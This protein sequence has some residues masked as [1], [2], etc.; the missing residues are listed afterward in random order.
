[1][2]TEPTDANE[3]PVDEAEQRARD[4][5]M[6]ALREYAAGRIL[7]Y[8]SLQLGELLR[9]DILMM[10]VRGVTSA[11]DIVEETFAAFTSS[12]EETAMG[13][14]RQWIITELSERSI[15][16]SDLVRQDA[17]ALWIIETKSQENTL[18]GTYR[19]EAI[20]RLRDRIDQYRRRHRPA[21][22]RRIKGV[23]GV[24]RGPDRNEDIVVDLPHDH[25]F[26]H[27]NGF[28][29][30]YM[31]G[32]PFWMWLTGRPGINSLVESIDELG[33]SVRQARMSALARLKGEMEDWLAPLSPDRDVRTI[34]RLIDEGHA[35]AVLTPA[36]LRRARA[37]R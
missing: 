7:S 15:D 28:V 35:P 1:M 14:T 37:N 16:L 6:T 27:L 29:Y 33:E 11:D 24:F 32:R 17:D 8:E 18:T 4:T 30:R 26:Y 13:N 5:V 3:I 34:L 22:Q 19:W 36:Q 2:T 10:A 21:R 12:S 25:D 9:K 31:V 20:R 23:L